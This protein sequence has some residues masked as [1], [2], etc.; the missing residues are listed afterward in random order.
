M[1]TRA[2]TQACRVAR[3]P[4]RPACSFHCS[5]TAP[6]EHTKGAPPKPKQNGQKKKLGGQ[7]ARQNGQKPS[8]SG[9]FPGIP[10]GI[11]R[12]SAID[13]RVVTWADHHNV[14]FPQ[15][16]KLAKLNSPSGRRLQ[17]RFSPQP[18]FR[19][20]HVHNYF[21]G[22]GHVLTEYRLYR[23]EK[24]LADPLWVHISSSSHVKPIVRSFSRRRVREGIRAALAE[25]GYTLEG[26]RAV[27]SEGGE[28]DGRRRGSKSELKGTIWVHVMDPVF[29]F[30]HP[31]ETHVAVGREIVDYVESHQPASR[32]P[33]RRKS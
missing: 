1:A 24:L 21:L 16:H 3:A 10:G 15:E 20:S 18:V 4:A 7:S 30:N 23:Y 32:A 29:T 28:R 12:M 8:G 25:R 11:P 9:S 19:H 17:F 33:R 26:R 14:A 13:P 22:F 2:L 5:S 31:K 6:R 27:G